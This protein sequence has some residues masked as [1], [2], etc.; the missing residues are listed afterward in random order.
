MALITLTS[1]LG[2]RD[3][4]A[5]AL[6]GT[7]YALCPGV[8]I[9]DISH[10]VSH[11]NTL[12]AAYL[13]RSAWPRFPEG[14]IHII[15][16]DPE[17]NPARL[18]LAMKLQGQWFLAADS[19]VLSLIRGELPA[20]V[21]AITDPSLVLNS[22]S[23]SFPSQNLYAPVAAWIAL[24]GDPAQAGEPFAMREMLWGEPSYSGDSLRGTIIHIDHFG[25]AVT[26]IRRA[27]FLQLKG[28]RRFEIF[29]RNL[30]L[31]KIYS[32]YADV[33]R[34]EALALFGDNQLLEIS[35]REGSA[36][37]LLGLKVHDMLTIE[38]SDDHKDR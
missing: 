15:A 32:S 28:D 3:P 18:T 36:A 33:A 11:F 14:T 25:N 2:V 5:A 7:L 23:K 1:D 4:Y 10:S 13:L 6:K 12:E 35:I 17:G 16:V 20:E 30:K 38:F 27:E 26:N 31:R 8:A 37:Q 24:G 19:G 34:G 29:I 21:Y 22:L 9:I